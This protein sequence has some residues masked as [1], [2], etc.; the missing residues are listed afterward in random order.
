MLML[1]I[2]SSCYY[3]FILR[4]YLVMS[5]LTQLIHDFLILPPE[6]AAFW[7]CSFTVAQSGAIS[8]VRK[9]CQVMDGYL[10]AEVNRA[11]DSEKD[12]VTHMSVCD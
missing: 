7:D 9:T 8:T 11:A 6:N 1:A 5:G 2:C 12:P 10:F 4:Y 3:S